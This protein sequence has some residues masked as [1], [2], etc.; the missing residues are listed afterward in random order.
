MFSRLKINFKTINDTPNGININ[1]KCGSTHIDDLKRVVL[2]ENINLGLAFDGDAD[3]ILAID[4]KGAVVNGDQIMVICANAFIKEGNLGNKIIVTTHMSNL[5]FDETI[6]KIGGLVIRTDIGDKNVL[7]EMMRINSVLG[8]EQSGHIIILPFNPNGDGI[9]NAFQFLN[10]L[11]KNN[12]PIS[13]QASQ[14]KKYNQK[15]INYEISGKKDF[16]KD[17]KFQKMYEKIN[18]YLNGEGR[19]LIRLSGT[20]SKVRV[21]LESKKDS[22]IKECKKIIEE[23]FLN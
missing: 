21:L 8:G 16:F 1:Q 13:I 5:G 3:R 11:N 10:A 12:E 19:V 22:K 6:N 14:M 15:L 2:E 9:I 20:E 4:E 7:K 17:K 18:K 23:Y